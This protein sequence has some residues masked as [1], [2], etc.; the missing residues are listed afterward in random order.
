MERPP[1][2]PSW[3]SKPLGI[4]PYARC[5][6]TSTGHTCGPRRLGP[7]IPVCPGARAYLGPGAHKLDVIHG[8]TVLASAR[9]CLIA[10]DDLNV[11]ECFFLLFLIVVAMDIIHGAALLPW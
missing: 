4:R 1:G 11:L 8:Q 3:E 6:A 2:R 7:G 5:H 10:C 9:L